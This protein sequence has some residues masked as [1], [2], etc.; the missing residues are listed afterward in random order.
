MVQNNGKELCREE[1]T[2]QKYIYVCN[3]NKLISNR[4]LPEGKSLSVIFQEILEGKY[5]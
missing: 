1:L 5:L 3:T 2:Y 4:Y